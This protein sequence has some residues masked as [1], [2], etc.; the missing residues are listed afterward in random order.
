MLPTTNAAKRASPAD[1]VI[2]RLL[3]VYGLGFPLVLVGLALLGVWL[4]RQW[5]AE[6]LY[7]AAGP[8]L[9]TLLHAGGWLLFFWTAINTLF[10]VVNHTFVQ[11]RYVFVAAPVLTVA[12]LALGMKLAPRLAWAGM[13]AGCALGTAVSLL[14]TWPLIG[15]KVR[16]DRDYADLAAFMRS[17]PAN[18]P[19]AHYSIGEAAFLSEHPLVDTGGITRPSVIPYLWDSTEDRLTLWVHHQ[20]ARYW[21]IDHAPEPGAVEVWGRE[22]P[23]T[24]WYLNPRRYKVKD[25]LEVWELPPAPTVQYSSS[26]PEN[27]EGSP[28]ASRPAAPGR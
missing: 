25:R 9:N 10:Y 14:A 7:A 21:V 13:A 3:H 6:P 22:I 5:R 15:N 19:V 23:A 28:Q 1:S 18:A 12:L 17:L 4:L 16:L 26:T 27:F 8:K 24:G 20:G 11:T 2:S